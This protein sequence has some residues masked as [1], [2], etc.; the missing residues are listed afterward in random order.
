MLENARDKI[1]YY[2]KLVKDLHSLLEAK[3][4]VEALLAR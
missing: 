2:E 1:L 4:Q 3:K